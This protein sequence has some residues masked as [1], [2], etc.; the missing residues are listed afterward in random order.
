MLLQK[1]NNYI[2]NICNFLVYRPE[3]AGMFRGIFGKTLESY[4]GRC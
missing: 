4:S 3:D 2:L 1:V